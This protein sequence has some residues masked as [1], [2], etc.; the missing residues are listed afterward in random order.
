[1]AK[2]N[3][4]LKLASDVYGGSKSHTYSTTHVAASAFDTTF[5]VNNSD[6][7]RELIE[8]KPDGTKNLIQQRKSGKKIIE[9]SQAE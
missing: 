4:S 9:I 3:T 8:F 1:M 2:L 5:K 6:T 7:F